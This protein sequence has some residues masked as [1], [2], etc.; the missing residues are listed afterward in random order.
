MMPLTNAGLFIFFNN[1]DSSLSLIL[2]SNFLNVLLKET[3]TEIQQ[4]HAKQ[5]K[6]SFTFGFGYLIEFYV[7]A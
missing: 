6:A 7:P 1:E 2:F 5:R 4:T 3:E